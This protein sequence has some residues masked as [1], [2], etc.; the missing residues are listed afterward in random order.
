MT[1]RQNDK[2]SERL[3]REAWLE[4]MNDIINGDLKM[5]EQILPPTLSISDVQTSNKY[6]TTNRIS[7]YIYK[8]AHSCDLSVIYGD[9]T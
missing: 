2:K 1:K 4:K 7:I 6:I 9:F 8:N 5:N 3:C